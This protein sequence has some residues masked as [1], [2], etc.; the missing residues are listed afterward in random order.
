M[1]LQVKPVSVVGSEGLV[2]VGVAPYGG[3]LW[4]TWFDRDL[5]LAGR[6][7]YKVSREDGRER[8]FGMRCFILNREDIQQLILLYAAQLRCCW[9]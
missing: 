7:V 4:R 2:Q 6:V 9:R 1:T 5:T 3:G 8:M